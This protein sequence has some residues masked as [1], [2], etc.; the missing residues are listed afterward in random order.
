MKLKLLVLSFLTL[1]AVSATAANA[2]VNV[3]KESKIVVN[4]CKT[5]AKMIDEK[6]LDEVKRRVSDPKGGFV[7]E[8]AYVYLMDLK[9]NIL[10]HPTQHKL[11]GKNLLG[12]KDPVTKKA[13]FTEMF[14]K[15]NKDVNANG[16]IE[17]HWAKPDGKGG[18]VLNKRGKKKPIKKKCHYRRKGDVVI[19]AGFYIE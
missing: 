4:K 11:I 19:F 8:G 17:Y 15:V 5:V 1:F 7:W 6:G 14:E 10:A 16:W 12:L 3:E 9:A 13:F 18:F 2:A